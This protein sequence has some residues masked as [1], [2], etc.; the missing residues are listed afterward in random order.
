MN[1]EK[2]QVESSGNDVWIQGRGFTVMMKIADDGECLD[3][4]L[5][6]GER[7]VLHLDSSSQYENLMMAISIARGETM[8]KIVEFAKR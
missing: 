8:R 2:F 6:D 1:A 7:C 4:T 3:F 5:L